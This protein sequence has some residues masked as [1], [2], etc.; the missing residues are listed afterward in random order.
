MIFNQMKPLLSLKNAYPIVCLCKVMA[1]TSLRYCR[2]R[3]R[4]TVLVVQSQ[5]VG[6]LALSWG[7]KGKKCNKPALCIFC[8]SVHTIVH[9][10]GM[11]ECMCCRFVVVCRWYR[12]IKHCYS[13]NY[14]V[15]RVYKR[16][17]FCLQLMGLLTRIKKSSAR[18]SLCSIID[19]LGHY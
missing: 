11:C 1:H 19:F 7:S 9:Y 18:P 15:C 10:W 4:P 8:T 2:T 5:Q 6:P 3:C 16:Q 17:S 13:V 14:Y 12:N